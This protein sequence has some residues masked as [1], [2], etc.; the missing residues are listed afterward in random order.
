MRRTALLP[1]AGLFLAAQ[2]AVLAIPAPAHPQDEREAPSHV[3]GRWTIEGTD[4]SRSAFVATIEFAQGRG[5]R[6]TYTRRVVSVDGRPAGLPLERGEA[7]IKGPYLYAMETRA[8]GLDLVTA[9]DGFGGAQVAPRRAV[10]RVGAGQHQLEGRFDGSP[11]R[12]GTEVLRRAGADNDVRLLVDG[13]EAFPVIYEALRGA[14]AQICLQTFSWFDDRAG[15]EIADLLI[16]K[17]REGV[18]VRCLIE[19]F[20]QKGGVGWKTGEHLRANGVEVLIHHT[21]SEG[22]KNSVTGFG[23]KLWGA[24]KGLFTREKPAARE[25]RGILNHDHRKL[26]VV[27]GAVAFTG[28]MNIGDKYLEGTTW[29]DLH[30]RVEGSAVAPMQAM[31]WER[32]HAAGGQGEPRAVEARPGPGALV[33]D[34]LET[35]PGLKRD[36]TTRYLQEMSAAQRAFTASSCSP[37]R[38]V[39]VWVGAV[40][41]PGR[42]DQ[43]A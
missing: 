32:W 16:A 15:R 1:A 33:V 38:P 19:S 29:H 42:A 36:V 41:A 30:C 10:Y 2:V 23:R 39:A 22:I 40:P 17:R 31:F 13:P 28:G 35:L 21:L 12:S 6:L 34:V 37:A 43:L 8:S 18:E 7:R 3:V 5:D 4:A 24:I 11:L 26:I 9:L 14:R 27:D 20:P 25:A